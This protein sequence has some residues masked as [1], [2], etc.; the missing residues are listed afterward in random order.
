MWPMKP[1]GLSRLQQVHP[2]SKPQD[3]MDLD[4]SPVPVV[5]NDHE[6]CL[7]NRRRGLHEAVLQFENHNALI[8]NRSLGMV[9]AAFPP[10]TAI[11]VWEIDSYP[12]DPVVRAIGLLHKAYHGLFLHLSNQWIL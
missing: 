12:M 4:N 6:H 10:S 2:E 3:V 7:F 9:D 1:V 11:C 5:I 8:I